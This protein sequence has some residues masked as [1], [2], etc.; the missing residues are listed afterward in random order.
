LTYVFISHD[1]PVVRHFADRVAVM[2]GGRIV[3]QG[4]PAEIFAN[5][6]HPYT[7]ALLASVPIA[8]P[9]LA[10]E[11]LRQ[12]GRRAGD[13]SRPSPAGAC[14]FVSRCAHASAI[15][16]AQMPP[17]RDVAAGWKAACW[18]QETLQ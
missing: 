10:R 15:C 7:R 14:P 8:N 3:E 17:L 12:G 1:L 4:V 16:S 18:K 9:V 6:A 13:A 2:L 11:I 5:P